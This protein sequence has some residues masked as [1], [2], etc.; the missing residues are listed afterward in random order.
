M[1]A[2]RCLGRERPQA[3]PRQGPAGAG[4]DHAALH[5]SPDYLAAD[6]LHP[7]TGAAESRPQDHRA[8]AGTGGEPLVGVPAA[9]PARA[10]AE[11]AA[12]AARQT[13]HH[14]RGYSVVFVKN[15]YQLLAIS[16]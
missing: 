11:A 5:L 13:A 4:T 16:L 8:A 9:Q 1:L 7:G 12:A 2:R 6:G 10:T 15:S 3:D 14:R